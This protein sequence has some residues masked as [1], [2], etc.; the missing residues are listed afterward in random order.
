MFINIR[1][2]LM[3]GLL[4]GVIALVLGL[5]ESFVPVLKNLIPAFT[6]LTLGLYAV[7]FASIHHTARSQGNLLEHIIGGIIASIIAG[8]FLLVVSFVIPAARSATGLAGDVVGVLL[9][10]VVAG[11]FG[12]LGME[13]VNRIKV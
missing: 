3:A 1:G 10:G 4:W 5:I 8:L 2:A 6:G 9:T 7:M 13:V 11:L 12:A